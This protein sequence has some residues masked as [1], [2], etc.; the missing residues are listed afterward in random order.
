MRNQ[1]VPPTPGPN[2]LPKFLCEW[3]ARCRNEFPGA[4]MTFPALSSIQNIGS[5]SIELRFDSLK[6]G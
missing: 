2:Y 3:K 5:P 1:P 6:L 4:T